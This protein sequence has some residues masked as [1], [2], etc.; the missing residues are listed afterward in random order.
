[1]RRDASAKEGGSVN[2]REVFSLVAVAL[3]GVVRVVHAGAGAVLPTTPSSWSTTDWY[4][5]PQGVGCNDE[6]SCIAANAA[7]CT[8]NEILQERLGT[9]EPLLQQVTTF[10]LL[11][12]QSAHKDPI[13]FRPRLA[14]GGRAMLVVACLAVNAIDAGGPIAFGNVTPKTITDAAATSTRLAVAG[15]PTVGMTVH[16]FVCDTTNPGCSF[17]DS[18]VLDAGAADGNPLQGNT[19]AIL[20]QPLTPASYE[21]GFASPTEVNTYASGDS[22]TVC[23]PALVNL[24]EWAPRGAD[25][26]SGVSADGIVQGGEQVNAAGIGSFASNYVIS[27]V[28][29][30]VYQGTYFESLVR[31]STAGKNVLMVGDSFALGFTQAGGLATVSGGGEANTCAVNGGTFQVQ[32][33]NYAN[34]NWTIEASNIFMINLWSSGSNFSVQGAVVQ[35]AGIFWGPALLELGPG[36]FWYQRLAAG[37]TTFAANLLN[38]G[39]LD[40]GT[41]AGRTNTGC[42]VSL[43]TGLWTCGTTLNAA[44]IDAN[45]GLSCPRTFAAFSGV[46]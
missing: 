14:N 13:F 17:V 20:Q 33:D 38:T 23:T 37:S 10:H 35:Q 5:D 41:S 27:G 45:G 2:R 15:L 1:L 3:L 26:V 4:I 9:T 22:A 29:E 6:N 30:V 21:G 8:F 42:T 34:D 7:C 40:C 32:L 43:S 28:T 11:S 16:D 12:S 46:N 44:N 18:L 19:V 36:T 24:E 25:S 39:G 31:W